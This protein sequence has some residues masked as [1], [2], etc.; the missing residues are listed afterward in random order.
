MTDDDIDTSRAV[1]LA[2]AVGFAAWYVFLWLLAYAL[3]SFL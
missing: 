1:L 2:A 3:E